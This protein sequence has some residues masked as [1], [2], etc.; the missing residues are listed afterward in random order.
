MALRGSPRCLTIPARK[1]L[2]T[3]LCTWLTLRYRGTFENLRSHFGGLVS[4]GLFKSYF[5]GSTERETLAGLGRLGGVYFDVLFRWTNTGLRLFSTLATTWLL[6]KLNNMHYHLDPLSEVLDGMGWETQPKMGF[7]KWPQPYQNDIVHKQ[8]QA[9][10]RQFHARW[11]FWHATKGRRH[12]GWNQN[13]LWHAPAAAE[14]N[15]HW[16]DH[17]LD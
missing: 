12:S 2:T 14:G 3:S 6:R 11:R 10:R 15:R 16:L 13:L 17:G 1:T 9:Q 5:L 7:T 8:P 4:W